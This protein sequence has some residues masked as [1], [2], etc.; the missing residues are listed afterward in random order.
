VTGGPITFANDGF[1]LTPADDQILPQLADKLKACPSAHVTISGFT[2]NS[3]AEAINIPLSTQRAQTVA[4]FLVAH[5]VAAAQLVVKG[6]GSINPVAPN[7]TPEGR[8]KN[9]RVEIVVS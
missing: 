6:L 7:D 8:A 4:D 1:S 3:G 9:R 2:D 5:G